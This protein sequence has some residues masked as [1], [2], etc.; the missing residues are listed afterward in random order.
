MLRKCLARSFLQKRYFSALYLTGDKACEN[1]SVLSPYLDFEE[2]LKDFDEIRENV[3]VRKLKFSLDDFL[4]EHELYQ[5]INER[6]KMIEKRRV[7]IAKMIRENPSDVEGLKIQGAQLRDDLKIMKENSYHLEDTFIH[8]Y[9][10]LPNL[11]HKDT[12]SEGKKIIYSFKDD[13]RNTSPNNRQIE[14]LIEFYDPTCYYMK[15]EAAKFDAFMPM[16]VHSQY[17]NSGFISFSNPDFTKSIVAEGAGVDPRDLYEIKEDAIE[18]KINLLHLAGSGSFLNYLSFVAKLTVFPSLLPMKLICSGKQYDAT[19]NYVHQDLLKVV[20]STCC[21]N[22]IATTD[23]STFDTLIS[24]QV[25]QFITTF[26]EF[27]QHFRIVY[28]PADE[29]KIAESCRVGVEMFSPSRNA[30][31]EVGN[32]SYYSDFISKRLLFNY[33]IGKQFAFP[34][35]YSGTVVNVYKLILLLLENSKDFKCPDW[36]QE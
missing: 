30:Y 24:E 3:K 10:S 26:K 7:E 22:F 31:V 33:K 20:Q 17:T 15:G 27:D 2:R 32:F 35:I 14:K 28:Y 16:Q 13:H 25:E 5:S 11:I 21:Q 1:F 19:N 29:L 12:P 4:K 23:G 6:K 18:N 36:L 8:N 9:L 34:H